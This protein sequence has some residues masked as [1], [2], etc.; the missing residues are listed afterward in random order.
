M[1][2]CNSPHLKRVHRAGREYGGYRPRGA[3]R[4]SG[5]LG[6]AR[7]SPSISAGAEASYPR[8][9]SRAVL[10]LSRRRTAAHATRRLSVRRPFV[11]AS[12]FSLLFIAL[13]RNKPSERVIPVA[14]AIIRVASIAVDLARREIAIIGYALSAVCTIR[15]P[16]SHHPSPVVVVVATPARRP[17]LPPA[18]HDSNECPWA[19]AATDIPRGA[20]HR[21]REES[22]RGS[23]PSSIRDS[24]L[25]IS[26][27]GKPNRRLR[28]LARVIPAAATSRRIASDRSNA[29]CV[30]VCDT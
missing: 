5:G 12:D 30:C 1:S 16:P 13:C 9:Q 20:D 4:R 8:A 19:R 7:P 2:I 27:R 14:R 23:R 17:P 21:P 28:I 18:I 24:R 3:A 15:S 10:T 22:R 6:R 26:A 29:V 25:P 11:P